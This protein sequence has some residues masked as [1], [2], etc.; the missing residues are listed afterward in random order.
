MVTDSAGGIDVAFGWLNPQGQENF[1]ALW[2]TRSTDGGNSFSAPVKVS[3]NAAAGFSMALESPCVID[4]AYL[5]ATEPADQDAE[6]VPLDLRFAQ[7]T[8][9]GAT[10]TTTNVTNTNGAGFP[11]AEVESFQPQLVVNAGVAEVMWSVNASYLGTS[12][13]TLFYSQ[14]NSDGTFSAP[15]TLSVASGSP[16]EALISGL[17]AAVSPDHHTDIAWWEDYGVNF[18]NSTDGGQ[19]PIP[20][21]VDPTASLSGQQF[22]I[23]PSSNVNVV[24]TQGYNGTIA[25]YFSRSAGQTGVFTTGKVIFPQQYDQQGPRIAADTDGNIDLVWQ[26]N[27]PITMLFSR[28]TDGGATFSPP[29][30]VNV[31]ANSNAGS[32]LIALYGSSSIDIAWTQNSQFL[33]SDSSDGG[34]SFSAPAVIFD[35]RQRTFTT[36][37]YV[38]QFATDSAGAALLLWSDGASIYFLKG[39]SA[40]SNFTIT[41]TP[42]TQSVLPGGAASFALTLT[43]AGGF[44]GAVNLSCTNLPPG[45]TCAF[46]SPTLTPNSSGSPATLSIAAPPTLA[47]GNYSI[48]VTAAS[49]SITQTQVVQLAVGGIVSSIS[50]Q[51]AIIAAGSSATFALSLSSTGGFAGPLTLGCSVPPSGITCSFNPA[52]LTVAASGATTSTLTVNVA[53]PPAVSIIPRPRWNLPET[54]SRELPLV[55]AALALFAALF[56]FGVILRS[57]RRPNRAVCVSEAFPGNLSWSG[58]LATRHVLS[59]RRELL[60]G[61]ASFAGVLV[62]AIGLISCSGATTTSHGTVA[63]SSTSTTTS[64]GAAGTGTSGTGTSGGTG[65]SSGSGG[66]GGSSSGSGGTGGSGSSVTSQIVVQAQSGGASITLGTISVTVP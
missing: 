54:V 61:L 3:L 10:F 28:S 39:T 17:Q 42:A 65:G 55:T 33:F 56:A 30:A 9:C 34:K 58:K 15:A 26:L 7:S 22:A 19:Q 49:G 2:F 59:R 11:N 38:E 52:Q 13:G 51:S 20:V 1:G 23:D 64:A 47:P 62:L 14:R 44:A 5:D 41:A 29:L 43:A 37:P 48:T 12:T 50:P 46:S 40:A 63:A 24:W 31:P 8:D 18:L 32:P 16:Q 25:P 60:L 66:S 6:S 36:F 57:P 35:F 21:A 4:V 45:A 27:Y 53:T